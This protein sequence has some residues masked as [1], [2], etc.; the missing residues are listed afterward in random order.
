MNTLSVQEPPPGKYIFG[1]LL[2]M[3]VLLYI[4][5]QSLHIKFLQTRCRSV[6][7][8][9]LCVTFTFSTQCC[10]LPTVYFMRVILP[11]LFSLLYAPFNYNLCLSFLGIGLLFPDLP[12]LHKSQIIFFSHPKSLRLQ[13]KLERESKNKMVDGL[14]G[15]SQENTPWNEVELFSSMIE[16]YKSNP[17]WKAC[18]VN[19]KITIICFFSF[20]E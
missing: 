11:P 3:H 12:R 15:Q 10:H 18:S 16:D 13:I 8:R 7:P 6:F 20:F 2:W 4:R 19:W 5:T 1:K 17:K 14:L 9:P